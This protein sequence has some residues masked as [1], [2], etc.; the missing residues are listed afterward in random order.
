LVQ[1]LEG[2]GERPLRYSLY[3]E[4]GVVRVLNVDEPGPKSYKVSGPDRML[5]DLAK[6]KSSKA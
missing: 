4:D 3:A 2:L 5:E 1:T 6:L